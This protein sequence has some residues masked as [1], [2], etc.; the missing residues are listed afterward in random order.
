MKTDNKTIKPVTAGN[1]A[2]GG[3][4]GDIAECNKEMLTLT[5]VG[6]GQ[7]A[8][9]RKPVPHIINPKDAICVSRWVVSVRAIFISS[10]A[11]CR[12]QFPE[13]NVSLPLT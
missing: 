11:V 5:Y 10:M 2:E 12:V 1:A 3:I 4:K 6:K 8:L 7:F 9:I 13:L